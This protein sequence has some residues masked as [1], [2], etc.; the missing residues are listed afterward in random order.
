MPTTQTT[1][2]DS[3]GMVTLIVEDVTASRD[4]YQD[5][6]GFEVVTDESFEMGD[7]TS[8]WLTIA[9]PDSAGPEISLVAVDD[10]MYQ[11]DTEFSMEARKGI[12]TL[13]MFDTRDLDAAVAVLEENDVDMGAVQETP[14]GRMVTVRDLDDNAF[15]ILERSGLGS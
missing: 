7:G 11:G 6:L 8:R 12:D 3:L 9:P 4:W 10:P 15:Q 5:V 13:W 2:I 1:A 14:W